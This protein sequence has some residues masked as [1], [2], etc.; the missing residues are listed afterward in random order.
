MLYLK[1]KCFFL[2]FDE[3]RNNFEGVIIV[4][5]VFKFVFFNRLLMVV[6]FI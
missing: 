6:E 1:K 4:E 3:G 2:Q 5:V